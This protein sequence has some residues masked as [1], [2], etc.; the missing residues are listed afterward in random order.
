[1]SQWFSQRN[2]E[3]KPTEKDQP[4]YLVKMVK[5]KMTLWSSWTWGQKDHVGSFFDQNSQ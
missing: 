3:K 1:M 5:S 4:K 2:L